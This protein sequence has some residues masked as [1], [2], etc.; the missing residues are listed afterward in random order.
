MGCKKAPLRR[1]F[2]V[3]QIFSRN[4]K[5]K[6]E[7]NLKHP[8]PQCK[9]IRVGGG[10][11]EETRHKVSRIKEILNIREE[12]N[13]KQEQQQQNQQKISMKSRT[14]FLKEKKK[15]INI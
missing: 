13:R 2:R 5:K 14:G 9:I 10:E 7:R 3:I 6:K 1:K 4:K 8:D 15:K 11:E 12:T